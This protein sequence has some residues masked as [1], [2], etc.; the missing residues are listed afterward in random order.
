MSTFLGIRRVDGD[1]QPDIRVF[2]HPRYRPPLASDRGQ[3]R[4][5][6]QREEERPHLYRMG[7]HLPTQER[8]QAQPRPTHPSGDPR[9]NAFEERI[10]L[11]ENHVTI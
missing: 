3:E 11:P 8:N 5:F 1:G 7:H 9:R 10:D 2:H 6:P 4:V